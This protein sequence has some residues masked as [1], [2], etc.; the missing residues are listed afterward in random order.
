MAVND[1]LAFASATELAGLIR[2]KQVSP[3][4]LTELY[5]ERIERL[6]GRLNAYLTLD[7]EGA[8][9]SARAAETAVM[10]G[11]ELGPLHGLP[12][13]IKDLEM[14]RG[15]RTTSGSL[16]F[17]RVTPTGPVT[18]KRRSSRVMRGIRYCPS[19]IASGRL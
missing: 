1:D 16:I 15:I 13:A 17:P 10:R 8:L 14:T 11:D 18:A 12:V 19:L 2:T 6:D 4:E 7:R 3:V 5:F 9:A